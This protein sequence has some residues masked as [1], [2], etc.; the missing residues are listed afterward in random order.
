MVFVV[1]V[2]VVVLVVGVDGGVLVGLVV[3]MFVGVNFVNG[4]GVEKPLKVLT[5]DL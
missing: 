2:L 4:W 1:A 3:A 5:V